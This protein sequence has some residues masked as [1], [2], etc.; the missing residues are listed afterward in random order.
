MILNLK[1]ILPDGRISNRMPESDLGSSDGV[2]WVFKRF[3]DFLLVLKKEKLFDFIHKK[4]NISIENC[5]NFRNQ[6]KLN[7]YDKITSDFPNFFPVEVTNKG[8][9][10]PKTSFLNVFLTKSHPLVI[11]PH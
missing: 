10:T 7:I 1:N 2:G 9:V 6:E 11:F 3:H 5:K 8:V 4:L